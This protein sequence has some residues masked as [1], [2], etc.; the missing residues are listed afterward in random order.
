MEFIVKKVLAISS[1]SGILLFAGCDSQLSNDPDI[2]LSGEELSL[3]GSLT[4]SL[5][6]AA[7][8]V[9]KARSEREE[10][11]K[12]R[13]SSDSASQNLEGSF[14][15]KEDPFVSKMATKIGRQFCRIDSSSFGGEATSLKNEFLVVEGTVCPIAFSSRVETKVQGLEENINLE[16]KYQVLDSGYRQLNDV[17]QVS[18]SGLVSSLEDRGGKRSNV[19]FE[20][21]M[22]SQKKGVF[23]LRI[24][25]SAESLAQGG[26]KKLVISIRS[27]DVHAKAVMEVFVGGQGEKPVARYSINGKTFDE[28]EFKSL[29]GRQLSVEWAK[30]FHSKLTLS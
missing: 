15:E 23:F 7:N 9:E 22:R 11:A 6:R 26:A 4:G 3:L 8:A 28:K 25:S 29:L 5:D 21:S 10:G 16:Y 1:L 13:I 19:F 17:D 12:R 27:K 14:S 30:Y 24:E 18:L 20:G 2:P